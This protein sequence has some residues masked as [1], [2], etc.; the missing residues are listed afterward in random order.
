MA[1]YLQLEVTT[2]NFS[3]NRE[4]IDSIS[5]FTSKGSV[6]ILPSHIP[7]MAELKSGPVKYFVNNKEKNIICSAGFV[8]VESDKIIIVCDLADE[9]SG[10]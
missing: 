5:F 6:G 3:L 8:R 1:R 9:K 7:F 2:P 10:G 4:K